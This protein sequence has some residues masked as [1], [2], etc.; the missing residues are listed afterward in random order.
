M[1]VEELT[2]VDPV[3]DK[4]GLNILLYGPPGAG[5]TTC[6]GSAP[7]PTLYVNLEGANAME[8]ARRVYGDDKFKEVNYT[9]DKTLTQVIN[10]ISNHED[11]IGSVVIDTIGELHRQLLH[12]LVDA[13]PKMNSATLQMF[14][15]ANTRI[16]RFCR[17]MLN[18]KPVFVIVCHESLDMDAS[19]GN[20]QK[21]PMTGGKQLPQMLSAMVDIVGYCGVT[22]EEGK[23]TWYTSFRSDGAK[24][25]K[26]RTGKLGVNRRNDI[27]RWV[28]VIN[29]NPVGTSER[30]E[31]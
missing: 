2:F 6:A 11:Q 24:Y 4:P 17:W 10:F 8:P 31:S 25:G 20:I 5:K 30:K 18:R 29:A 7:G 28:Q 19:T 9:G 15:L 13:D 26:D 16:E 21:M 12:E 23:E 3:K 1:A 14:G 22:L 27:S